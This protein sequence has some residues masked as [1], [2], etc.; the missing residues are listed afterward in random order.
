M[1]IYCRG[2]IVHRV[3]ILYA[4][5][6]IRIAHLQSGFVGLA[7]IGCPR[8]VVQPKRGGLIAYGRQRGNRERR[9]VSALDNGCY[10]L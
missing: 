10:L 9:Y 4:I 7:V 1:H 6:Y 2:G 3:A 8:E 5:F